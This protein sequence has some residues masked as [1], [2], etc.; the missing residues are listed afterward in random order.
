M[1]ASGR[2]RRLKSTTY[3]LERDGKPVFEKTYHPLLASELAFG[4]TARP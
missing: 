4:D 2:S 1:L 3:C